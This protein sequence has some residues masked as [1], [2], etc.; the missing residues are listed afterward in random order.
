M[1]RRVVPFGYWCEGERLN[2]N[3]A[4]LVQATTVRRTHDAASRRAFLYFSAITHTPSHS[5]SGGLS[6]SNR[7]RSM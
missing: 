7:Q 4:I 6:F 5:P 2:R 1:I 3:A